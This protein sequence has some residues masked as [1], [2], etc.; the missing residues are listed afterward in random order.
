MYLLVIALGA[1]VGAVLPYVLL[2]FGLAI[3][4]TR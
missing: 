2:Y 4:F 1:A 3:E